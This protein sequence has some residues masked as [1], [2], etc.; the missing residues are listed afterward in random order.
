M[1]TLSLRLALP[2]LGGALAVVTVGAL[3]ALS[4]LGLGGAPTNPAALTVRGEAGFGQLPLSF[5]PNAGQ[6]D[7]VVAFQAHDLGHT[8]F[9]TA[10]EVQVALPDETLRLQFA[11]ANA[12][13]TVQGADRALGTF[14]YLQ[15]D[16]PAL[17]QTDLPT[18]AA[19]VYDELYPGIALR[20]DGASGRLKA[21]YT[22]AA[23]ADAGQIVWRHPGA[24]GVQLDTATGQLHITLFKTHGAT[25][26]QT[27]IEEA[28][29]AWQVIEGRQV[30]VPIRF[31]LAAD[32]SVRFDLPQGYDRAHALVIDPTIVYSTYLGGTNWDDVADVA[33]GGDGSVYVTGTTSSSNFL[34]T[35]RPGGDE[36]AFVLK[37]KA[38]GSALLYGTFLGGED[39]DA[40]YGVAVDG[41]GNA[42]VV[43]E[44]SSDTFPTKNAVQAALSTQDNFLWHGFLVR[45]NAA[46]SGLV[47]GTYLGGNSVSEAAAVAVHGNGLAVVVGGTFSPDFL[48]PA[49]TLTLAG[50]QD[51]FVVKLDTTQSGA[52]S[53]VFGKLLGGSKFDDA[54][55]VALDSG[56]NIYVAGST[57]STSPF[58][59]VAVAASANLDAFA[60]K[61]SPTGALT[62]GAR[63][64]G[65][66]NDSGEGIAVD[67]AGNAYL[68]GYTTS[69]DFPATAGAFQT[70]RGNGGCP[71]VVLTPN[72]CNDAFA[73]KLNA[74]G[75]SLVYATYLAGAGNDYGYGLAVDGGGHA[76]IV[77]STDSNNFPA[78]N[79]LQEYGGGGDAFALKLSA[80]GS[81][82][83]YSTFLGG[84]ASDVASSVTLAE[85]GV[86][87]IGGFT[88]GS[89]PVKNA[90]QGT[91]K[92]MMEGFLLK[93]SDAGGGTPAPQNSP[94]PQTQPTQPTPSR[95]PVPGLGG[96]F[97]SASAHAL[98][99]DEAL[100]YTLHLINSGAEA[101]TATVTDNLPAELSYVAGS[102]SDGGV[103]DAAA[104]RLTWTD[105]PVP[106]G[107]QKLL[108]FDVEAALTVD[109]P[110]AVTNTALI[111]ADGKTYER[112]VRIALLPAPPT[113]DV[114][115]PH[116]M[117]VR[118]GDSD[119][120]TSRDVTVHITA[121]DNV[122]VT[123]MLIREWRLGT[124]PLPRW[125]L[126]RETD[127]IPFQTE[128]A[129][130]LGD[131]DGTHFIGVWVTD[132]AGNK[133]RLGRQAV[134]FASL[135][136][137]DASVDAG[138]LVP[139]LV[140]YSAGASVQVTL[141]PSS[142]DADLYV[143]SP[144]G[145][146]R[147]DLRSTNDG[148]A[149]DAV[150]FTAPRTGV[151]LILV[152]GYLAATYDLTIAPAGG[153]LAP[154]GLEGVS[155]VK[156]D[157]P[158]NP[159]LSQTG[160]DPLADPQ[161][162]IPPADLQDLKLFLPAVRR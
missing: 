85:D 88:S 48:K 126:V 54:S 125:E 77:G 24:A 111:V 38:D 131:A 139:Y 51:A 151:Y 127:W 2:I 74:A 25:R 103:Y 44:T 5:V 30:A 71:T 67:G 97:K 47:Y 6:S 158:W 110:L 136:R 86:V 142:G 3:V 28:P 72:L 154:A 122:G 49:A 4:L 34:P 92:G 132:A 61:L 23:G 53:L 119:V 96:S 143:W 40:G 9:F 62:Y 157:L 20:Y 66:S 42:Y 69:A 140:H 102:A 144:G 18:Y 79:F 161:A 137:P 146:G 1:K 99:P 68:T 46:G 148:T 57:A 31:A 162:V 83:T 87:L 135:V 100:T 115:P 73:A 104:H 133:S 156:A 152:H 84:S 112:S 105:V 108:T 39:D 147:P 160:L 128:V 37:I 98:G 93:L 78:D 134:D 50:E 58:T 65:A 32:G 45:L 17:W 120:L 149:V 150:S 107:S 19:V 70:E 10:D 55:D 145:L 22:I 80:D 35:P 138:G 109:R 123:K 60:A 89:F 11:G 124:S 116:V 7:P 106:A 13:A 75:T 94:T 21:T 63:L 26:G 129:W 27:L 130:Q 15:G 29:I 8:L 41:Q 82:V 117:D 90:L 118:L 159:I 153:A 114:R 12:G 95:T 59:S 155:A 121:E 16:D 101:V 91:R 52:A 113:S 56:G 141:A 33:V 36:D 76:Y 81:A 43:G 64:G 14:S